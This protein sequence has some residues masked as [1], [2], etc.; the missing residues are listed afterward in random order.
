MKTKKLTIE[1]QAI[2]LTAVEEVFEELV[3][4]LT[5]LEEDKFFREDPVATLRPYNDGYRIEIEAHINYDNPMYTE[6]PALFYSPFLQPNTFFEDY[7]QEGKGAYL[8]Y[9]FMKPDRQGHSS[10][11]ADVVNLGQFKTFATAW[12]EGM[13][14]QIEELNF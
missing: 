10:G 11:R 7:I 2:C 4:A 13:K 3:K 5:A 8:E 14:K 9:G 12:V 1:A 6:L